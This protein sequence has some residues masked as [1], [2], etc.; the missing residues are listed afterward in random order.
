MVVALFSPLGDVAEKSLVALWLIA[1]AG[2]RVAVAVTP[3]PETPMGAEQMEAKCRSMMVVAAAIL[4][5]ELFGFILL[6]QMTDNQNSI[7]LSY[8]E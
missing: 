7:E 4:N 8:S 5:A 1:K 2:G 6:L 3:K